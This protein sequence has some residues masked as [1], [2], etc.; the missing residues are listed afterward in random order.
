MKKF[1]KINEDETQPKVV[2]TQSSDYSSLSLDDLKQMENLLNTQLQNVKDR[3]GTL[4]NQISNK[5]KD[6]IKTKN[7]AEL[8]KFTI[9]DYIFEKMYNMYVNSNDKNKLN[10]LQKQRATIQKNIKDTAFK[11]NSEANATNNIDIKIGTNYNYFSNELEKEIIVTVLSLKNKIAQVKNIESKKEFE[12]KV[13]Q[14]KEIKTEET[15]NPEEK[16]NTG[17]KEEENNK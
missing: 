17:N 15:N 16:N 6:N 9:N 3:F 7:A 5:Y 8:C 12:V 11:I 2:A 1:N 13:D 14:L 10:E 4:L